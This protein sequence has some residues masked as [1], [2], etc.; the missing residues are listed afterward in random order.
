[1]SLHVLNDLVFSSIV[2]KS[3]FIRSVIDWML[4]AYFSLWST[5]VRKRGP[6]SVI[7]PWMKWWNSV[8]FMTRCTSSVMVY[9]SFNSLSMW[10]M[11][12]IL[13]GV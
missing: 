3:L 8:W 9:I 1:M 2:V 12:S 13:V 11:I 5:I 4:L 6:A 7:N 10:F